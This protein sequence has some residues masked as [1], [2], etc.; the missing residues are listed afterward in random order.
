MDK[1]NVSFCLVEAVILTVLI[2]DKEKK[3]NNSNNKGSRTREDW[4]LY[5]QN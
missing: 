5:L 1:N 2:K 4:P 3:I